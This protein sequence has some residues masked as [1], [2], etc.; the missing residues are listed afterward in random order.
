MPNQ[1]DS[2]VPHPHFSANA[3]FTKEKCNSICFSMTSCWKQN[4]LMEG[5]SIAL[6]FKR[7]LLHK[8]LSKSL[9]NAI[10]EMMCQDESRCMSWW[11]SYWTMTDVY[12]Y[13]CLPYSCRHTYILC[14]VLLVL[15]HYISSSQFISSTKVSAISMQGFC[16][17]W[18]SKVQ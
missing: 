5:S 4:K 16:I 13:K 6:S 8:T 11:K 7:F 2:L 3:W 12:T 15:I 17:L 14:T 1:G 10:R 9:Y 18:H